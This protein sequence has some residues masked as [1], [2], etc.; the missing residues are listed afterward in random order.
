MGNC[1]QPLT[2]SEGLQLMNSFIKDRQLQET[3]INFKRQ[4]RMVNH[5]GEVL[6]KVGLKYWKLFMQRNAH[7]LV[8]KRGE[9]FTCNRAD[10][11][12]LSYFKQMYDVIYDQMVDAGVA[13]LW[14]IPVFMNGSGDIVDEALKFGEP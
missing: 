14:E 9:R 7:R 11:S 4:R 2:A 12:K 5:L 8:T 1:C 3:L 10:W 13:L 6:G